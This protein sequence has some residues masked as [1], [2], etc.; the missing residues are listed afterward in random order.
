M[1]E[2]HQFQ[3]HT[4]QI[5]HWKAEDISEFI[6][7]A[8]VVLRGLIP[9]KA[10]TCFCYLNEIHNLVFS[11]RLRIEGWNEDHSKYFKQLLCSH[12]ILYEELYGINACTENVEYSLHMPED[13]KRHSTLDNY[14]CYLYER[15]VKYYKQQTSNMKS[16]CKTFADRACQLQFMMT[17]L[18]THLCSPEEATHH[19]TEFQNHLFFSVCHL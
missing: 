17:F 14:W 2:F 16:L 8:P 19:L 5:G 13:V 11:K 10:Y 7:V 3:I 1:F 6:Q 15:Q 12:A 18:S 9:C 4:S